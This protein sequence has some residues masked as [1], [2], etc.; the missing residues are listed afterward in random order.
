MSRS[1]DPTA[2]I[3][4]SGGVT[5][6][7]TADL[8]AAAATVL[9]AALHVEAALDE[10]RRAY[11][12]VSGLVDAPQSSV[13]W[14]GGLAAC[15]GALG[16]GTSAW[17]PVPPEVVAARSVLLDETVAYTDALVL[18]REVLLGLFDRLRKAA[19]IYE[20]GES[21]AE[22]FVSWLATVPGL[23]VGVVLA[24]GV[25]DV[26]KGMGAGQGMQP[27]RLVTG[28]GA[29]H[30]EVVRGTS[31]LVG[32]GAAGRGLSALGG[33]FRGATV[34]DAAGVLRGV[35]QSYR[36][37]FEPGVETTE[38][39]GDA[40]PD[41]FDKPVAR[42]AEDLLS[43]IDVVYGTGNDLP[44]SVVSVE[45]YVGDDQRATWVVTVPGTQLGNPTTPFSMTSN[46]DL[47][48]GEAADS[49]AH[50]L[51][52]MRQAGIPE[53]EEVVLV[54]HSQGGMV[55]MAVA[56]AAS[57]ASG[58][59]G[60]VPRYDVRQVLTAGAPVGL[61]ALPAGVRATHVENEQ[62]GVSQLD[63]TDNPVGPDRVT[64]RA[65]LDAPGAPRT[66][67]VPHSV[68]FHVDVLSRA[69]EVGHPGLM[70][71]LDALEKAVSG[72]RVEARYFRGTLVPL[73]VAPP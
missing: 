35:S 22:G 39:T 36:R 32:I 66:E 19:G 58:A 42:S 68:P 24:A 45:K 44:D 41:G 26:G 9:E 18:A 4:V 47:V 30:D 8:I 61:A 43:G 11:G 72:D 59:A 20:E 63:G 65:D 7:E 25:F 57:G 5:R 3:V 71:N 14:G 1:P 17:A 50:V 16:P 54:G 40:L 51:D 15:Y 21:G 62:E 73:P 33:W 55:A 29:Y 38:L 23:G 64:V 12:L 60:T 56:A 53:G 46:F 34:Q 31:A 49:T 28:S 69:R 10:S 52:A 37:L 2:G 70:D 13:R 67:G 27:G 48:Q 6:V